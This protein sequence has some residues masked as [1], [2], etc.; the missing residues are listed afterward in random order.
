MGGVGP[1]PGGGVWC[2]PPC[3]CHR[4]LPGPCTYPFGE[5]SLEAASFLLPLLVPRHGYMESLPLLLKD[6]GV[7]G[8]RWGPRS[9][10][11]TREL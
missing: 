8:S 3:C 4:R 2:C 1:R 11:W 9:W 7:V 10:Y 6:T 5:G